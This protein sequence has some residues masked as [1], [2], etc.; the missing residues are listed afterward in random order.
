MEEYIRTHRDTKITIHK[1]KLKT[2]KQTPMFKINKKGQ[3]GNALSSKLE[4]KTSEQRRLGRFCAFI[5]KFDNRFLFSCL[6][7]FQLRLL[8][9]R[10]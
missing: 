8:F 7:D 9:L 5:V 3:S 10:F 2:R 6:F 4:R 1:L